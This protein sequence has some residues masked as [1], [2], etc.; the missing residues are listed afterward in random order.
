M[1]DRDSKEFVEF[2]FSLQIEMRANDK[3]LPNR[4]TTNTYKQAMS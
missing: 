1:K 3:I 4:L 2:S